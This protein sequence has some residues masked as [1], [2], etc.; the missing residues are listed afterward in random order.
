[1]VELV[2]HLPLGEVPPLPPPGYLYFPLAQGPSIFLADTWP[3]WGVG[4]SG[5]KEKSVTLSMLCQIVVEG[6]K[7]RIERI[8]CI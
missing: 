8:L 5:L 2:S 6:G 1:M 3:S 4:W 7:E